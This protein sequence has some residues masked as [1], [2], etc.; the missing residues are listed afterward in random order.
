M[1]A[2]RERARAWRARAANRVC[3]GA[4]AFRMWPAWGRCDF[5]KVRV[6]GLQYCKS[7]I[8]I[9]MVFITT[10]PRR[11]RQS[12]P[13]RGHIM[14]PERVTWCEGRVVKSITDSQN[15]QKC[16]VRV[17]PKL[18]RPHRTMIKSG[19]EERDASRTSFQTPDLLEGGTM[20]NL[21]EGRVVKSFTDLEC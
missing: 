14:E 4:A 21:C 6:R 16:T 12:V 11:Q 20:I 7:L 3:C 5:F 8:I 18:R 17:N 1:L 9:I 2:R 10:P 19:V 15:Y 13:W